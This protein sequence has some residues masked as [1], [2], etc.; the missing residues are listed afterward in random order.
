MPSY[1]L[2]CVL[3]PTLIPPNR[4]STGL[5]A[6]RELVTLKPPARSRALG[7]ILDLT[8]H[9]ETAF[10]IAAIKAVKRWVPD[11]KPMDEL[12]R[13]FAVRLLR[14]LEPTGKKANGTTDTDMEEASSE[15]ETLLK[16]PY[17]PEALDV[18][19]NPAQI[20]QHVQLIFALCVKVPELLEECVPYPCY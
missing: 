1:I 20:L 5:D 11:V 13:A 12:S 4:T 6:L 3:P 17:L 16:T 8:T 2:S 19:A 14:R 7:I 18:P 15:I 10:R 9:P